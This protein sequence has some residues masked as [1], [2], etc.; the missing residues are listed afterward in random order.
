MAGLAQAWKVLQ[1]AFLKILEFK[2]ALKSTGNHLKTLKSAWILQFSVGVNTVDSNL[3]Q[4][5]IVVPIFGEGY[6]APYE[7]HNKFILIH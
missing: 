5:K 4:F 3:N 7:S 2:Y 1:R 6:T